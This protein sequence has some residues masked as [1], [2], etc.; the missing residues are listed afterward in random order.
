MAKLVSIQGQ[1]AFLW[2]SNHENQS[3][4]LPGYF[5]D[6]FGPKGPFILVP[7]SPYILHTCKTSSMWLLRKLFC[8]IDENLNLDLFW[9]ISGSKRA[10]G[11]H[12]LHVHLQLSLIYLT[13][14]SHIKNFS[15]MFLC[16]TTHSKNFS[17]NGP[18][19]EFL[20]I[21]AKKGPKI[22]P[23]VAVVYTHLKVPLICL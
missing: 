5:P 21:T 3:N 12:H 19:P 4:S 18:K 2:L 14:R 17:E 16:H 15:K 11:S 7:M 1:Q 6:K 23:P 9:A 13:V 22:W 10:P 20:P 8:N